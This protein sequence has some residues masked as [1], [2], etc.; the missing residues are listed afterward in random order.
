MKPQ[1]NLLTITSSSLLPVAA[2]ILAIGIFVADTITNL[3]IA[4]P[5]FYTAVVL[6][7][8][9]ICNRRGVILV[10]A[11]CIGV[12]DFKRFFNACNERLG[13]GNYQYGD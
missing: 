10:G 11:G 5:V 6:I 8:V 7:S 1:S 4:I 12:D 2:V 9:R 3:E 13:I